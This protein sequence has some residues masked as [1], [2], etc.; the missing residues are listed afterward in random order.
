MLLLGDS[1]T[2]QIKG[3]V[4][5]QQGVRIVVQVKQ[6]SSISAILLNRNIGARA[7]ERRSFE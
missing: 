4:C 1:H 3:K 5:Q 2:K 7:I 6:H